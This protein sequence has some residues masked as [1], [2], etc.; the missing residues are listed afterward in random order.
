MKIEDF[1]T[2]LER[3]MPNKKASK[4]EIYEVIENLKKKTEIHKMQFFGAPS[5]EEFYDPKSDPKIHGFMVF[6]V[7]I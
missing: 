1:L 2:Q 3:A 7:S 5:L 6:Q 4:K